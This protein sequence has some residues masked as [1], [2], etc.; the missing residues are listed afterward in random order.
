MVRFWMLVLGLMTIVGW[1]GSCG[2]ALCANRSVAQVVPDQTLPVGERSVVTDISSRSQVSGDLDTQ[3]DGGAIRGNNLF[4]SFQQFSIPTG[5]SASFNN[6]PTIT[7]IITRVTGSSVSNID[8][9]IRANG[10]ANLFLINPNGILF[11]ANARLELGESFLAS[12][13]E[14]FTFA[15]GF[16]FSATSPQAPPL[17]A[18]GVPIG[19]QYG[20]R[21]GEVRLARSATPQ[22]PQGAILQV[23]NGQTLTL[24]GGNVAI[25]G[26]QLLA[27]G[28]RVTLGGI[29]AAGTVGLNPDG[30]LSVPDSIARAD[31][32]LTNAALVD[33]TAGGG[34]EIAIAARNLELTAGSRLQAGIGE[35]LGSAQAQAGKI[36]IQAAENVT[37]QGSVIENSVADSGIA[38]GGDIV[39][40]ARSL[41]LTNSTV[42]ARTLGEG[43][44]GNLM[45]KATDSIQLIGTTADNQFSS[46]LFAQANSGSRGNAG[47]LSIETRN[48]IVRDG[49]QVSSGTFG[50][51]AGGN[52]TVKA[53]DSVQAIGIRADGRSPSGLFTQ[54]NSRG[55]AGNLS[56]ETGNLIVRDGAQVGSGTRGTGAGG[57]L[58]VKATDS[59]QLIGTTADNRFSS[60][61]FAQANRGSRGNA[62][63]LSIE[64]RNLIV[65]DG[66]QVG[67]ATFSE[68]AGGN[69][70]VK[71]TDSVQAIGESADGQ[72][73]SGLFTRT[74]SRGNAG[75]LSIET[76]N[77]IV[78]DGAEVA[79]GTR[80]SGAGGNLTV[81]ATD[82]I[83]I[84][85]TSKD[86]R[87]PSLLTARTEASGNAGD[88]TLKTRQLMIEDGGEVSSQQTT[89]TATGNVGNIR[90]EAE[91]LS[92][93]N[94]ASITVEDRRTT[95]APQRTE[96]VG[97][98]DIQSNSVKIDRGLISA[99]TASTDGGN[100][101]L[102]VQDILLLRNGGL[103]STNAGTAQAGGNGGNITFNG[104]FIVAVPRE[105][106]NIS[107]NAFTGRGGNIRITTQGLFGIEPRF[108]E[109]SLSDITASSQ[110]G[111]SG[112]IALNTPD[113]DPSRGLVTLPTELRD[114][115]GLI[116]S[117]CPADEG[118]SFSITGNGG[119]PEDPRQPLMGNGVWLDDRA[120][121]QSQSSI[122]QSVPT[123]V[124]AQ[125]WIRDRDGRITLVADRPGAIS[126]TSLPLTCLLPFVGNE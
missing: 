60:G 17:L 43:A 73:P 65:R 24:A 30:S 2:V 120:T 88:I 115:S 80:S 76:R 109:T 74:N 51:G 31:V 13:A 77:L 32:L 55:N 58:T 107:A 53:T 126:Q 52:L 78:R 41:F 10:T 28:G 61:L 82:S 122:P 87:S 121:Q 3:I 105:N 100:I 108:R 119:L 93:R 21:V 124:E 104:N 54:A 64:T 71:A 70:T 102:G 92:V 110:F 67:S 63:S 26:G 90:I 29:S 91:S 111:I 62:G 36:T 23:P 113:V 95:V 20:S 35:G 8:G 81:K 50:E 117:G 86:G 57:N 16:E 46:G 14:S 45:V 44:G 7:N 42:S 69:L 19:L 37:L 22:E 40:D 68:G 33:V 48:L 39:I 18:I 118:N 123:I 75:N 101:D 9:L 85:R 116:A 98:I 1:S 84:S 34:G 114:T 56:I 49:A 47:D 15:N 112:T 12:T 59:I 38:N 11:G 6:A 97:N 103:I 89:A 4:H 99:A 72:L 94:N 125:G 83:Q 5:G 96:S 66:A 79:S 106:S 27:P 25:D